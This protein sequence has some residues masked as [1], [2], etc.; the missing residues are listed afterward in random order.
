MLDF[1]GMEGRERQG[2]MLTF[3]DLQ[4]QYTL[5]C[6]HVKGFVEVFFRSCYDRGN[7]SLHGICAGGLDM[8]KRL[9]TGLLTLLLLAGLLGSALGE[10]RETRL[11]DENGEPWLVFDVY[12]GMDCLP[13]P[14][15]E[16]PAVPEGLEALYRWMQPG[17]GG[18]TWF[19]RMPH[20]RVLAS[21]SRREV[22]LALRAEE[23]LGLWP[24]IVATLAKTTAYVDDKPENA[25]VLTVGETTW[26]CVQ[27]KAALDGEKALSVTV[28]GLAN[29]D[30]GVL[31]EV[32]I[33]LPA[34][35]TYRYDDVAY[36]EMQADQELAKRWLESLQ[37]PRE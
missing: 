13:S 11:A 37:L 17:E 36:A 34:L 22:G 18:D 9:F 28:K 4:E 24:N 7:R 15:R 14:L 27:T 10:P 21:A 26:L 20:G 32:W 6:A 35:A 30:N 5:F 31:V 25:S 16:A 8:K 29:C 1:K 3:F 33:A 12:E 2:E 19:L 23:M